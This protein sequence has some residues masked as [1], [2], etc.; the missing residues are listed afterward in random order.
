MIVLLSVFFFSRHVVVFKPYLESFV[1]IKSRLRSVF[2]LWDLMLTC[3]VD[4]NHFFTVQVA[5]KGV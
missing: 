5:Y 3:I 2:R 4:A 1:C